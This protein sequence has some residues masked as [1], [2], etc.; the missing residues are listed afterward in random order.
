MSAT[1]EDYV[2][3]TLT[4]AE[5]ALI[6]QHSDRTSHD[7]YSFAVKSKIMKAANDFSLWLQRNQEWSHAD[8]DVFFKRFGYMPCPD[9]EAKVVYRGV[10]DILDTLDRVCI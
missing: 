5:R 7:G 9:D 6:G 3:V 4:E 10:K 8:A 1:E 2:S